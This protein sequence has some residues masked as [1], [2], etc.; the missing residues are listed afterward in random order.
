MPSMSSRSRAEQAVIPE[1]CS[2]AKDDRKLE[3]VGNPRSFHCVHGYLVA[4]ETKNSSPYSMRF[5]C[6]TSNKDGDCAITA[7]C[8]IELFLIGQAIVN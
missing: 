3:M 4:G 7:N 8:S 6:K 1:V 5:W 2:S